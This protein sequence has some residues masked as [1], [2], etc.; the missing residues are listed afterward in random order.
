MTRVVKIVLQPQIL[1]LAFFIVAFLGFSQ[2]DL[3]GLVASVGGEALSRQVA[4]LLAAGA[5]SAVIVGF[6]WLVS[7]S[8][9]APRC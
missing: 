7:S 2:F 9:S 8:R 5:L 4:D 6:L 1:R 3:A